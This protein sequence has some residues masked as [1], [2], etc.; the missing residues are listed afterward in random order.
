MNDNQRPKSRP[1]MDRIFDFPLAYRLKISLIKL[2]VRPVSAMLIRNKFSEEDVILEAV[3]DG[4]TVYEVGCGD[5]NGFRLFGAAGRNVRYT[6]SDYNDHMVDYCRKR[7]PDAT[8]EHY[9][10]GPYPHPD[11]SFDYCIIRHVLHHIPD[12]DDIRLTVR[13]AL[14]IATTVILIEPLQSDGALLSGIKSIYWRFTDGG[15]NYMTLTE[16]HGVL[17]E[18]G[19]RITWEVA[20]SPCVKRSPAR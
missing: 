5:G 2:F 1:F 16:L 12:H 6:A 19:A 11:A 17:E 15:V 20:Q 9:S 18:A 3:A 10:G 8:W 14:R 13:E 4:S 7:H